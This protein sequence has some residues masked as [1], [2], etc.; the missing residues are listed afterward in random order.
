ME[1]RMEA[2][3]LSTLGEGRTQNGVNFYFGGRSLTPENRGLRNP[4]TMAAPLGEEQCFAV[5]DELG[6]NGLAAYAAARRMKAETERLRDFMI[7][8]R[9]FLTDLFRTMNESVRK[10]AAGGACAAASLLF[11]SHLVYVCSLGG[12]RAFRLR[13]GEFMQI[14]RPGAVRRSTEGLLPPAAML[15]ADLS[16]FRL[17]PYVAKGELKSR[18]QYLLVSAGVT[19]A[20]SN[21]EIAGLLMDAASVEDGVE[22]LV[23]AARLKGGEADAAALV[24]R[25]I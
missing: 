21:L 16:A 12:V 19:D 4:V 13:S 11:S 15:G 7:P 23:E 22:S 2:A 17:D 25:V 5:F 8:E 9:P 20:L 3:C 14:S 18:D 10:E 24:C 1:F 6:G